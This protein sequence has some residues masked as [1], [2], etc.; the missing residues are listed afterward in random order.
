M[1]IFFLDHLRVRWYASAASRTFSNT[2]RRFCAS[3]AFLTNC[4][5]IVEPPCTALPV[6]TSCHSARPMPRMSTPSFW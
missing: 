6:V 2:V 4:C 5:V 3:V 1:R